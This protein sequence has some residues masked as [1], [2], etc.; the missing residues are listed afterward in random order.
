VVASLRRGIEEA[1]APLI[2]RMD[3]DDVALPRRLALQHR[4]MAE[5][6]DLAVLGSAIRLTDAAGRLIQEHRFETDPAAIQADLL[7]VERHWVLAHPAVMMRREAVRAAGGYRP[8]FLHAED[9]DLWLR[10]SERHAIGNLAETLL[11]HRVLEGS[12]TRRN[13][14]QQK[15]AVIAALHC[16]LRR[17]RGCPD[18]ADA[19]QRPVDDAFL[20]HLADLNGEAV[21]LDRLR[22][23]LHTSLPDRED[24]RAAIPSLLARLARSTLPG[25]EEVIRR[26]LPPAP[27]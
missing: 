20:E 21:W 8:Q 27:A 18:P 22:M 10:L 5:R 2:A 24:D 7:E 3:A 16:A 4:A 9:Y 14:G 25:V 1:R 17:R 26:C 15:R 11:E 19:L 13:H 12:V 23:L 6:P